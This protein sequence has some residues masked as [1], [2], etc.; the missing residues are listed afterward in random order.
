MEYK[1]LNL[2]LPAELLARLKDEHAKTYPDHR[3]SFNAWV[4][5]RMEQTLLLSN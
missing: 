5:Q 2:R 3:Q 4:I 1:Y